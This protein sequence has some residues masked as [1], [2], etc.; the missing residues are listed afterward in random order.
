MKLV[1]TASGMI[2]EVYDQ[3]GKKRGAV[4]MSRHPDRAK[5][6]FSDGKTWHKTKEEAL[7]SIM[8]RERIP[9]NL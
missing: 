1:V 4:T 3:Y 9:F 7:L 8:K 6:P 5:K 2:I